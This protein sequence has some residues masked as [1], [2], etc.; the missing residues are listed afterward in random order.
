MTS[1]RRLAVL[2][3]CFLTLVPQFGLADDDPEVQDA[4]TVALENT[5]IDASA[6]VV[7]GSGASLIGGAATAATLKMNLTQLK[8]K[9]PHNKYWNHANNP[10]SSNSGQRKRR[11]LG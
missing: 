9:F 7:V 2:L 11:R 4:E 6:S 5:G 10:G 1:F 8:A 3:L